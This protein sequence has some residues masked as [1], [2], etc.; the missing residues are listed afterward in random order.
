MKGAGLAAEKTLGQ[1]MRVPEIEVANLWTINADNAEEMPLRHLK[2]AAIAWRDNHLIHLLHRFPGLYETGKVRRLKRAIRINDD[3]AAGAP[4][5][6]ISGVGHGCVRHINPRN[7]GQWQKRNCPVQGGLTR[8]VF[9]ALST[10][11]T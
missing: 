11:M 2:G 8:R 10:S 6:G 4:L 5:S 9:L 1:I 3:W 7:K